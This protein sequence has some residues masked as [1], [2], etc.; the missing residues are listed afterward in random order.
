MRGAGAGPRRGPTPPPPPPSPWRVRSAAKAGASTRPPPPR[1]VA[2]LL[3]AGAARERAMDVR[4]AIAVYERAVAAA[5]ACAEA[6]G[7]AAKAWSDAIYLD[8]LGV[9]ALTPADKA[10][11]NERALV[12]CRA[13]AAAAPESGLPH[14]ACCVAAGRLALVSDNRTKARLAVQARADA[15][16]SVAKSPDSDLAHHLM[17]RWHWEMAR[18]PG[19]VRALARVLYGAALEPGCHEAATAHYA[20]AVAL[21]PARLI[22]RVELGRSLARAGRYE[23]ATSQLNAALAC[24]V[25]DVNALLQR[26]D[27]EIMLSGLRSRTPARA[28]AGS[29]DASNVAAAERE[30]GVG[31]AAGEGGGESL[32]WAWPAP[33][34]PAAFG[35][36]PPPKRR[37]PPPPLAPA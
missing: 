6:L 14:A 8:E 32:R 29:D 33:P 22:H 3:A 13:A 5:P 27:A 34:A 4:G 37:P 28:W 10:A 2:A 20:K 26:A 19:V 11:L 31:G 21:A 30:A 12:L 18:T 15:V 16:A 7:A 35:L 23:E 36:R 9:E 17:G 24:E 1:A 25:E